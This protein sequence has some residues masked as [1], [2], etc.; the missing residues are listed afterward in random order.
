MRALVITSKKKLEEP[1]EEE[2]CATSRVVS[3]E[4]KAK[5][6]TKEK[7]QI[8]RGERWKFCPRGGDENFG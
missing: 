5:R 4:E 8:L 6:N 1:L 2:G 3:G 7:A